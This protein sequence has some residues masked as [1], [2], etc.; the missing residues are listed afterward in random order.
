MVGTKVF[1]FLKRLSATLSKIILVSATL[2]LYLQLIFIAV[3]RSWKQRLSSEEKGSS[4]PAP[5]HLYYTIVVK[6]KKGKDT[7][8]PVFEGVRIPERT[9]SLSA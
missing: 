1:F 6:R 8:V 4:F 5:V 7:L 2:F 3:V 9:F